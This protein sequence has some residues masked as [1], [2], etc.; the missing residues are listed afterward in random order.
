MNIKIRPT[1]NDT[2]IIYSG[3]VARKLLRKGYK[4]IDVMPNNKDPNKTVFVFA[5]ADRMSKEF[6]NNILKMGNE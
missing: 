2:V 6:S 4:I 5:E 1:E 3:G